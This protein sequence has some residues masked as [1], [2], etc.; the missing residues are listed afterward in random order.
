MDTMLDQIQSENAVDVHGCLTHMR[1]QRNYMV[2]TE[3]RYLPTLLTF[4]SFHCKFYA[5]SHFGLSSS[6]KAIPSH[7]M[8]QKQ[9][10]IA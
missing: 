2:Q 1:S 6:S 3:V 9:Y 5:C 8:K 7:V 10:Q 4:V